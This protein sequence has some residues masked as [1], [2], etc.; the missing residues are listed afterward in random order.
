MECPDLRRVCSHL[1]QG[2]RPSRKLTNV[3]DIKRYLN[4]VLISRD[5]LLVVQS[6]IPYSIKERIVIPRNVLIGILTALHI[7]LNCPK[8]NQM[9]T[10]CD[11]YFFALDM[12]KAITSVC[13][14]CHKCMALE[15]L[16][17]TIVPQT[18][19]DPPEVVGCMFASD[20]IKREKQNILV[21]RECVTS[22]T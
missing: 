6:K 22:Y 15:H 3:K 20:V 10:V 17:K 1:R 16:P 21:V 14:N 7:K 4:N 9:K 2:T 5:G 18:T 13:Q 19:S 8:R 12:E 11:R